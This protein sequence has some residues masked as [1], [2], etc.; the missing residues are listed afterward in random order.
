M[1]E[2]EKN[3]LESVR[4]S[5]AVRD[6]IKE[7]EI[8]AFP[9]EVGCTQRV[10]F[11]VVLEVSNHLPSLE[12][13]LENIL[14]YE[15]IIESINLELERQ[16]YNLL[17]TLA[18]RIAIR[19]L[20]KEKVKRVYVKLEKLDRITGALG[21]EIVRDQENINKKSKQ[22]FSEAVQTFGSS[23]TVVHLP[24]ELAHTKSLKLCVDHF[25]SKKSPIIIAVDTVSKIDL[26]LD[27]DNYKQQVELVS[28]DFNALSVAASDERLQVTATLDQ[29]ASTIKNGKIAVW[30]PSRIVTDSIS[31]IQKPFGMGRELAFW[32]ASKVLAKRLIFFSEKLEGFDKNFSSKKFSVEYL[33][34]KELDK[35]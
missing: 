24:N 23:C 27:T 11:N 28:A 5:I 29:L 30:L 32:L 6:F 10:R 4:D 33:R 2:I 31:E 3:Y 16:R 12:D 18:E 13:D 7:I 20:Q 34:I 1:H 26:S 25:L 22:I 19:C 21:V 8:G 15:F 14:S 9:S 17:E 35:F